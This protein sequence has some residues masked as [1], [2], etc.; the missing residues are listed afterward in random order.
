[1]LDLI[2]SGII[3]KI[4]NGSFFP[5]KLSRIA[6]C[7]FI[8]LHSPSFEEFKQ[9]LSGSRTGQPHQLL[10]RIPIQLQGDSLRSGRTGCIAG[11][12]IHSCKKE[13]LL[14]FFIGIVGLIII[15][16]VI[17]QVELPVQCQLCEYIGGSSYRIGGHLLID[18]IVLETDGVIGILRTA[19]ERK[20]VVGYFRD[21]IGTLV[22][23]MPD[24]MGNS[25]AKQAAAL[26]FPVVGAH[27]HTFGKP[28]YRTPFNSH[29]ITG[30]I[31]KCAGKHSHVSDIQMLNR[32]AVGC[33]RTVIRTQPLVLV[34]Q[35]KHL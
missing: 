12:R 30:G 13:I 28:G 26:I 19:K 20:I 6:D 11:V 22:D 9:I 14:L 34:K 35:M 1:M 4:I 23:I 16:S 10:I 29:M 32:H 15:A 8:R 31:H 17:S 3:R 33:R 5:V 24:F 7:A 2:H 21:G 25:P 27:R 18:L